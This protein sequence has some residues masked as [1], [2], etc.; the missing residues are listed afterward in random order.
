MTKEEKKYI[1]TCTESQLRLIANAVEDWHRFLAGE[2]DLE[3][4][5]QYISPTSTMHEARKMLNETMRP[6]IVPEL[7]YRGSRYKWSGC[8]CPNEHQRKAIAMSYGIY[9]EIIHFF[10]VRRGVHNTYSSPTLTCEEGGPLI[11][12]EDVKECMSK[13]LGLM[14]EKKGDLINVHSV[15]SDDA[16]IVS[17]HIDKHQAME[18]M[19]DLK[20]LLDE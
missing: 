1:L 18:L 17:W 13:M 14:A 16:H 11:T 3:H 2:C 6:Y 5:T 4:I 19:N 9:R 12:I 20:R 15:W 7:K 10:T 8:G